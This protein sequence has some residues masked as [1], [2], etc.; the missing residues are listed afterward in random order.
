MERLG[1]FAKRKFDG[2]MGR[3]AFKVRR[4]EPMDRFSYLAPSAPELVATTSAAMPPTPP[5]CVRI[6]CIS[7]THNEHEALCLPLGDVLI[8][9]GDCLTE[10]G[11]RH[12]VRREGAIRSVKPAGLEI[13][14]NFAMWFGAQ[15]FANKILV[16]GNHDLV[17]QGLGKERVQQ[18]LEA[19]AVHGRVVYLEHE[20]VTVGGI[21]I[22][23]SPFAYWGGKNDAFLARR[24]DYSDVPDGMDIVVTHIPAILPGEGRQERNEDSNLCGALRRTGAKLHVSGHC[25]W[26]NGLYHASNSAGTVPCVVAS[27]C[28]SEW[29]FNNKLQSVSG[30]RGD[31]ADK[32]FGGY[33][34][35]L[36]G[37]VCDLH[38]PA[39][40]VVPSRVDLVRATSLTST[41]SGEASNS[42]G[43]AGDDLDDAMPKKPALLFFGPPNDS[44]IL[45]VV[46]PRLR[47]SFD[48]DW[49]DSAADGEQA[50][51]HRSY[52]ACVAKLGTRGNLGRDVITALR[53]AQGTRPVVIIHSA[54]AARSPEFCEN[55][56]Q[57]LA[58]NHFVAPGE[59]EALYRALA[60]L[61]TD[62]VADSAG[63]GALSKPPKRTDKR[64]ALLLFGPPNDF[65][66]V[67]RL[68]PVLQ[69]LF[70]VTHVESAQHGVTVAE[71]YDFAVCVAKL[72]TKGNLGSD[73]IDAVRRQ[74]S[75]PATFIVIHSAT[76]AANSSMREALVQHFAVDMFSTREEEEALLSTLTKL[77]AGQSA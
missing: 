22:F 9:S 53:E 59:E 4:C 55:M 70:Q 77:A 36:P 26:A 76:A 14:T 25:H 34:L 27:V 67:Q 52:V 40:Y 72:G 69:S 23:G 38:I 41:L 13:F 71:T 7:D 62:G 61:A 63:S 39:A 6:V 17:L 29:H 24:C 66:M 73:V 68:L 57:E 47:E 46:L 12:V 64:L 33:N 16:A 65:H 42:G 45:R 30:M 44:D 8:H 5:E 28:D 54:T 18:I 2:A 58:V 31:P 21:K 74:A 51:T 3:E 50:A 19:H 11:V 20:A 60:P 15:E 48:V 35:T 10:S 75:K 43:A 37:I 56:R 49:V 32:T 1:T